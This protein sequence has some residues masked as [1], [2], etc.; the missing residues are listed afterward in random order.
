NAVAE[1]FH[2]LSLA[3]A[4]AVAQRA[5]QYQGGNSPR[6]PEHGQEAAQFVPPDVRSR[7]LDQR[8]TDMEKSHRA[9]VSRYVG[10]PIEV[11]WIRIGCCLRNSGIADERRP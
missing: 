9:A 10:V 7:L 2:V 11:P 8:G 5:H 3:A 1:L 4:K 6:D